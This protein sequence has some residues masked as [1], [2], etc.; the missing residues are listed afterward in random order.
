MFV[1]NDCFRLC[2]RIS[3]MFQPTSPRR[4]LKFRQKTEIS[5][6]VFWQP[7]IRCCQYRKNFSMK[8]WPALFTRPMIVNRRW[9]NSETAVHDAFIIFIRRSP[10]VNPFHRSAQ[11][12][13]QRNPN[14]S[15]HQNLSCRSIRD[16]ATSPSRR[17]LSNRHWNRNRLCQPTERNEISIG[18]TKALFSRKKE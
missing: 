9:P 11:C 17:C 12:P 16:L 6:I 5:C 15:C 10:K 13:R 14:R 3:R 1:S 4:T 2:F 8:L 18:E 7:M